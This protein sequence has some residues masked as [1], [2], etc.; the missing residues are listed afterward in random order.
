MRCIH[1]CGVSI[2]KARALH[3]FIIRSAILTIVLSAFSVY[4]GDAQ[5][6]I[7]GTVTDTLNNPV[8]SA[9]VYLSKTTCGTLTDA[10]GSFQLVIPKEGIY[11]LIASFVGYRTESRF[12]AAE[13]TDQKINIVLHVNTIPLNEVVVRSR[14]TNRLK[15]YTEFVR[16][17]IGETINS[18]SCRIE[19]P[20]ELHF[21]QS[22]DRKTLNCFSVNPLRISNKS[23]GYLI[24]YELDDFTFNRETGFLRFRGNYYFQPM[25]GNSKALKKWNLNRLSAYYGSRMHFLRSVFSDSL[26][27]GNYVLNEADLDSASGSIN[28]VKP[29][30]AADLEISKSSQYLSLFHSKPVLVTYADN[31]PELETGL[32][33]F[34]PRRRMSSMIFKDFINIYRNGFY[35]NP[36]AVTW[37]GDMAVERVADLLPYD[38]MLSEKDQAEAD[39]ALTPGKISSYLSSLREKFS[40]EQVFVHTDRNMYV[41]GD[42]IWFQAYIR[43]RFTNEF[44]SRSRS[45]YVLLFNEKHTLADSSRFRITGSTASG[46]LNIPPVSESGKYRLVAFT[47]LMQNYD[48]VQAFQSDLFVNAKSNKAMKFDIVFDRNIYYPGD[49]LEVTIKISDKNDVPVSKLNYRISLSDDDRKIST[50]DLNTGRFGDSMARFVIPDTLVH[51]LKIHFSTSKDNTGTTI[52]KEIPVPFI[53]PYFDLRFLPEGGSMISGL[54]QRIGFNATDFNGEPVMIK[55]ILKNSEGDILDTIVSQKYGPGSFMCK[56]EKG[57]YV[58][59]IADNIHRKKWP[60]PDPV[61]KGISL[62]VNPLNQRS[63]AI[64]AESNTDTIGNVTLSVTMNM[65]SVFSRT[66]SLHKVNSLVIHTDDLLPGVATVTLFDSDMKQI[67]ERHIFVNADKHIRFSILP[68]KKI[69]EPGQEVELLLNM[70]DD[71]GNPVKG[72]FSVSVA[73]S[74]SGYKPE[75]PSPDISYSLNFQPYFPGNLPA[76]V[77]IDGFENLTNED[78]DLLLLVYGWT[79]Y[80][81]KFNESKRTP[82]SFVNY[83]LLKMKI[84]YSSGRRLSGRDLDL[85]SLEGPSVRH[86]VTNKRGEIT[87]PLDSLP[88]LTRSVTMIPGSKSRRIRGSVLGIPYNEQYFKSDKYLVATKDLTLSYPLS[89]LTETNSLAIFEGRTIEIPEVIIRAKSENKRIYHDKYEE[90]YQYADVISL[91]YNL[92]WT[93]FTVKDALYRLLSP[94]F[95]TEKY[96]FLRPPRSILKGAVPALVVLDGMPL[97]GSG[98]EMVQGINP[99][100]ITSFTVVRDSRGYTRYGEAAQGGIIFVNTRSSDPDF[101]KEKTEWRTQHD[102]NK[103]LMPIYLYRPEKEFYIPTRF[104]VENNPSISYNPTVYWAPEI[105]SEGKGPVK[106]SFFNPKRR[107]TYLIRINGATVDNLTGSGTGSYIVK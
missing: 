49:T 72:V 65:T 36:Y 45:L 37:G 43:N 6:T 55:G 74:L 64:K 67:T 66:F 95:I 92:L 91:D 51:D 7:T 105:T 5:T 73:D 71:Q 46:W 1:N 44:E 20:R 12:I 77:L 57:L 17:F 24:K 80:D 70:T 69:Y 3:L 99:S 103:I 2:R 27:S 13:G 90:E 14:E 86:L 26:S 4:T 39:S 84:L 102:N 21:S 29:L 48:P 30:T 93:S 25:D 54:S 10:T 88:E 41:P 107:G 97:Y 58:E 59:L 11:E 52:S 82:G 56:S 78:L 81:W 79:R 22:S 16:L 23:L 87:L 32:T 38:F 40:T 18:Q 89:L 96:V 101:Y 85:V 33:G 94:F 98:W 9:S 100:E 62:A 19:N 31:H 83:D 60:L 8:K 47:G 53:D 75:I 68:D 106:L 34:T 28:V 61:D 104:N 76:R 35:D 63:F 42:T 15:N 50:L